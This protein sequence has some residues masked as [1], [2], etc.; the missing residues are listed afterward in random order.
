MARPQI[1]GI[2]N[3]T[4]DSFSDGGKFLDSNAA[5]AQA[6]QLLD[7]GAD[8]V[9]FG[10]ASSNPN[11]GEVEASEEISR[12]SSVLA[13]MRSA[14]I[15]IDSTKSEV[16]RF[17]L[18]SRVEFLNDIRGFPDPAL[19]PELARSDAKLV[20]MHSMT[21]SERAE[22]AART[23]E[24]VFASIFSFFDERI[25]RLLSAGISRDRVIIDP[26]MGFFLSSLPEAS[27]AVLDRLG[28][29]KSRYEL[30]VMIC[31]SRKSFLRD[32][33]PLGSEELR[34]RSL[35]AEVRAAKNGADY[36]RTHEPKQLS[37]ALQREAAQ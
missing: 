4:S 21:D 22:R 9:E 33:A 13:T 19:Y 18:E 14:R 8:I 6:K 29:L 7:D 5:I 36:I 2:V 31:V 17:A 32:G 27:F 12:L 37:A 23:T 3:I 25:A 30:P 20:V 15:S 16:L 24:E 26:G 34:R 11:A 1:V 35:A 10:A 28:E